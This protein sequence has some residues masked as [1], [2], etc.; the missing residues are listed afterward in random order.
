M[1]HCSL[2]Q[3][4]VLRSTS[5]KGT[6]FQEE[7]LGW[8]C[9]TL[10]LRLLI[11]KNKIRVKIKRVSIEYLLGMKNR[12]VHSPARL[13]Q[14]EGTNINLSKFLKYLKRPTVKGV[15]MLIIST[16]QIQC[17]IVISH[18]Y[19]TLFVILVIPYRCEALQ[20]KQLIKSTPKLS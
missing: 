11:N 17:F 8:S 10:Q 2:L 6:S 4:N 14:C 12:K 13:G 15:V 19:L 3:W 16:I 7:N 18:S 20:R 9:I 5:S 1:F